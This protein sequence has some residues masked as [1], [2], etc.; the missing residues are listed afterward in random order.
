MPASENSPGGPL[1]ST[2][3]L[4]DRLGDPALRILDASWHLPETGRDARAEYAQGHIPGAEFL[5]IDAI[6]DPT[7]PLPHMLPS[8]AD[9]ATA[10][11]GLGIGNDDTVVVYD[12]GTVHAAA[13]AWWMFRVFG[14]EKVY[15]LD[16]GLGAWRAEGR[17]LETR[18]PTAAP[19]PYR[20]RRQPELIM[21]RD[22]VRDASEHGTAA[23][24][25][26]RGPGRFSGAE[27]EPRAGLKSGHIPNSRNL[28]YARLYDESGYLKPQDAL[29]QLFAEAGVESETSVIATCGS[30]VTACSLALALERLG[31][32]RWAVYDGS[33][34]EWGNKA[35]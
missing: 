2:G 29:A 12:A 23:I 7:S 34:A 6:S 31:H 11:G 16:G 10:V 24:V 20:A 21:D 15:V 8:A 35:A 14:H 27:P 5:D 25:D 13:R 28:H 1:V 18:V 9:F 32:T 17:P 33:W 30:G 26:A 3:W 19:K 4:A 22:A